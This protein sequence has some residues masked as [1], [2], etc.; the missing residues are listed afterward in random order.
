METFRGS[1]LNEPRGGKRIGGVAPESLAEN[2]AGKKYGEN[3]HNHPCSTA[4]ANRRLRGSGSSGRR[5]GFELAPQALEVGIHFG[6][7]L[8]AQL[9]IL[10]QGFADNFFQFRER[11][12]FNCPGG[13]GV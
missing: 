10:F 3:G 4:A 6:G 1:E 11:P 2:V 13:T 7:A 9:A 8:A 12:R 5:A